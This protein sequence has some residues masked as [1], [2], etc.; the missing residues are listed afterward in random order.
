MKTRL[1]AQK[2]VSLEGTGRCLAVEEWQPQDKNNPSAHN[3]MFFSVWKNNSYVFFKAT[4]VLEE[5][6][7][8][9][10]QLS[11]TGKT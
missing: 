3:L 2:G 4:E 7:H 6:Q 9:P 1:K 5:I 8:P 10:W 11:D